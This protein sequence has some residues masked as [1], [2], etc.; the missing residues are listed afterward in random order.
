MIFPVDPLSYTSE[1]KSQ[2][3]ID[4]LSKVGKGEYA[5]M[6]LK[7]PGEPRITEFETSFEECAPGRNSPF[8][9]WSA[10]GFPDGGRSFNSFGRQ[11]RTRY[12]IH[13]LVFRLKDGDKE[14][15]PC[16]IDSF[17]LGLMNNRIP[18]IWAGFA[19]DSLLYKI[20][21]M[22]APDSQGA[23]D[24]YK[25]EIQNPTQSPL[26]SKLF[27]GIDGPPDMWLDGDV[28]RGQSDT[29]L[30]ITTSPE[31]SSMTLRDWGLCDNRAKSYGWTGY[32]LY[33]D[34]APDPDLALSR[35]GLDGVPIVYR[36]KAEQGK[37]YTVF[38]ATNSSL[39]GRVKAP[40]KSG[41]LIF[42]YSAEGSL[43]VK[44][45]LII[46]SPDRKTPVIARL[47]GACDVD[48]DG[49]IEVRASTAAESVIKDSCLSLIYVFPS[50]LAIPDT[51]A[52]WQGKLNDKCVYHINVGATP[53]MDSGNQEYNTS[54][55][56]IGRLWLGYGG[57]IPAGKTETYWLKVPP[58][59]RREHTGMKIP[60]YAF[61]DRLPGQAIPPY[62]PEKVEHLRSIN[63]AS[64]ELKVASYWNSFFAKAAK[65]DIPD[66]VLNDMYLSRLATRL[67]MNIK[68]ADD[69]YMNACSPWFYFDFSYRDHC[70]SVR[71]WDLAGRHD[72]A[73]QL[74][75]TY[76]HEIDEVPPGPMAFAERPLRVG[77]AK[78]GYWIT[79]PGQHDTMGQ[80]L[81]GIVEHYRLSGDKAWLE[82]KAYQ[83]VR[84]GANWIVNSRHKHMSE[85]KDPADIRYGLLEPG[86]ME[87]FNFDQGMHD[88]Y[89]NC[90]AVLGLHEAA[91]AALA[92]G[93]QDDYKLFS[94]EYAD[95]RESLLRAYRA[96]FKRTSLYSGALWFGVEP[97]GTGMYG[98]WGHTPILWPCGVFEPNDPMLTATF[99][100]MENMYNK[101]GGGLHAE[102]NAQIWPYI[103]VDWAIS[104]IL[105][106]ER[107]KALEYFCAYVDSAGS[108]LSWGEPID[109]ASNQYGGDQ[110][111]NWAD[112]LY[113]AMY[114]HLFVMDQDSMLMVTPSLFRRWHIGTKPIKVNGLATWFGEFTMTIQPQPSG[115]QLDYEIKITP[116]GDQGNRKLS[117]IILYPRTFDGRA[118]K[119]VTIDGKPCDS[120]TNDSVIIS[121]PV[122]GKTL[123]IRVL[124]D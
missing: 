66:P 64:A 102:S 92:V 114:R 39:P 73:Q 53:E 75:D 121:N 12:P 115:K 25:I 77:M 35:V 57:T 87:V 33:P 54:D 17:R 116:V 74:A 15:M 98:F 58:I 70:Y 79:R 55:M 71:A 86:A 18:A 113:V 3:D 65:F 28:V 44:A 99:R 72:L 80:N 41:D 89:T 46:D 49:Y 7:R 112:T 37:K 81:W 27:A 84:R 16:D 48:G 11:M 119:S 1:T 101:W 10:Y 36:M 108:T 91:E 29:P 9:E 122:R 93:R 4:V 60:N 32:G 85:V 124:T 61:Y 40:A 103:G 76:C 111:H 2:R 82:N 45:D 83:Y 78:E 59:H 96:T 63:P 123:K 42:E 100:H 106:G 107:D 104:Y 24:L 13:D 67:V 69:A 14:I 68:L 120:F 19:S 52:V 95:M 38:M 23:F 30:L 51:K 90:W 118:V 97:A 21:V 6:K 62:G 22:C 31:S 109:T 5:P 8:N 110:P 26:Q 34:I 94:K 43:P 50:D 20:T 117:K 56:G 105:R 88:F 47:D